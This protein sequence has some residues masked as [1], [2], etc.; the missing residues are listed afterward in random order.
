MLLFAA[1]KS[2]A[3]DGRSH[4]SLEGGRAVF[5]GPGPNSNAPCGPC[6][7]RGKG[8]VGLGCPRFWISR[9]SRYALLSVHDATRWER[10]VPVGVRPGP[11]GR[12][13]PLG[14]QHLP[15]G[16]QH[17]PLGVQ[18]L[19]LGVQVAVWC[20]WCPGAL[21]AGCEIP[22]LRPPWGCGV[23][24]IRPLADER[25]CS[26]PGLLC[27]G[28]VHGKGCAASPVPHGALLFRLGLRTRAVLE[29]KDWQEEGH[30]PPPPS[31]VRMSQ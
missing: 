9:C 29:W 1:E 10:P 28:G 11:G 8:W 13:V 3:P 15:L 25:T 2:A 26:H 23:T 31:R 6:G 18:H 27:A 22:P 12:R 17:L 5:W 30:P 16:V 24:D 7:A 20:T 21:V 4:G 14:V 19:P